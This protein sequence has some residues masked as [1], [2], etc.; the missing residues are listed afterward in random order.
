[1]DLSNSPIV[2]IAC[3]TYNQEFFIAQAI[4]GFLMQQTTFPFEIIIYDDAST[5]RTVKIV[6]DYADKYP[7]LIIPIFQKEN[8]YSKG[9]GTVSKPV[10]VTAQNQIKTLNACS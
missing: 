10:F 5:D 7:K 6:R 3:I 2:S 8:Q 4:E 9:K 1:M